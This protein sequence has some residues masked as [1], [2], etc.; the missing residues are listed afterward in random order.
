MKLVTVVCLCT[1]TFI[2]LCGCTSNKKE[3]TDSSALDMMRDYEKPYKFLVNVSALRIIRNETPMDYSR[4]AGGSAEGQIIKQLL[5]AHLITQNTRTLDY[6]KLSPELSGKYT[7]SEGDAFTETFKLSNGD[8]STALS[9]QKLLTNKF[10]QSDTFTESG[11]V[12]QDGTLELTAM[13]GPYVWAQ[14]RGHYREDGDAAYVDLEAMPGKMLVRDGHPAFRLT[15]RASKAKTH[16]VWY[17]YSIP[18]S[19]TQDMVTAPNGEFLKCG[20]WKLSGI[21]GLKL[22]SDTRASAEFTWEAASMCKFGS[23]F[24]AAEGIPL[25]GTGEV[26]FAKK[27]DGTWFVDNMSFNNY[28]RPQ[29]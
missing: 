13:Q 29:L 15:G 4:S 14:E 22:D 20:D 21:S 6:P 5:D 10:G 27:P 3:L 25:N 23:V 12:A 16:I 24:A 19:V 17:R 9:G 18:A 8:N 26:R 11:T 28:E 1:V 2:T 7:N